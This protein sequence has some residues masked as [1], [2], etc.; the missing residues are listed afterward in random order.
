MN[1]PVSIDRPRR[2]RIPLPLLYTAALLGLA[3]VTLILL[4]RSVSVRT[5]I[6]TRFSEALVEV[7]GNQGDILEVATFTSE[8]TFSSSD[9]LD[10]T[11]FGIPVPL[12]KTET[13]L[14]V[15]VTYRFHVRLS[16]RWRF[17]STP[18]T[19]TVL[20]PEILPSLPP[21]P[22][23]SNMDVKTDQGW[24]RFNAKDMEDRVRGLVSGQLNIRAHKLARSQI[25]RD[26][27]RHSVESSLKHHIPWLD[28]ECRNKTFIVKFGSET[29]SPL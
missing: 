8:A 25:I 5:D 27:A 14:K 22:D 15:P 19:V 17:D 16:D 23:I 29:N 7:K 26:A 28:E 24:A 18:E 1:K 20:A 2:I 12:G 21:A 11:V 4:N 9:K 10:A 13:F 3:I 6:E